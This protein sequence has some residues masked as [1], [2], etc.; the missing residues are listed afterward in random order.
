MV[1]ITTLNIF[2]FVWYASRPFQPQISRN[3][4]K[5]MRILCFFYVLGC[6]FRTVSQLSCTVRRISNDIETLASQTN[7]GKTTQTFCLKI[8][9]IAFL[10]IIVNFVAQGFCWMGIITT[11]QIWHVYEESIWTISIFVL[12]LCCILMI[13]SLNGLVEKQDNERRNL[14][15]EIQS[16]VSFM[17]RF[18]FCGIAY[19][20]YMILVDIV[21][22]YNR[23]L[24]DEKKGTKYFTF[25]EGILDSMKCRKFSQSYDDWKGDLSWITLYF[26]VC[27]WLSIYLMNFGYS[28]NR[29]IEIKRMKNE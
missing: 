1:G 16:L 2:L 18:V 20:S 24:E 28:W 17:K 23:F 14:N 11:K 6:S 12:S 5:M 26:S 9:R 10:P 22:Y 27:V 15:G 25:S 7:D 8:K 4:Q 3:Y 19:C 29:E 13:E 21:L